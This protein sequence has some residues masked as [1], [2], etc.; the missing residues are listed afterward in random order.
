MSRNQTEAAK[1][2]EKSK[3]ETHGPCSNQGKKCTAR[4]PLNF[5]TEANARHVLF[6]GKKCLARAP[7]PNSFLPV[8]AYSIFLYLILSDIFCKEGYKSPLPDRTVSYLLET[9]YISFTFLLLPES[10]HLPMNS[11]QICS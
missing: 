3:D 9:N 5:W 6:K 7:C 2:A 11:L 1:K 8:A 10:H 4:A